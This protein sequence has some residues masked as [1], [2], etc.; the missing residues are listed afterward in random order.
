MAVGGGEACAFVII[1]PPFEGVR[2]PRSGIVKDAVQCRDRFAE[3]DYQ[4][5][6]GRVHQIGRCHKDE[7]YFRSYI[8]RLVKLYLIWSVIYI[9]FGMHKLGTMMEISG[10]LWLAAL[11]IALFNIGTYFHLWYMSALIFAMVFCH[12][13]LK[14]FSMKALLITG[15]VL[16]LFGLIETYPGLITN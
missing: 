7:N 4:R 15:G 2:S 11:P 9:P 16:F 12:L 5:L 8:K 3:L 6:I 10:A 1:Y 14:K 13:F